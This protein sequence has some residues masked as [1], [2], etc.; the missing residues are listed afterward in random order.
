VATTRAIEQL[1][2]AYPGEVRALFS[3]A[4][5]LIR[6]LLPKVEETVDGSAPVVGYGYGPGYRGVACTLILSKSEVKLGLVRGGE[7]AD[8]RGLLEGSGKVHRYVALRRPADLR[9]AGLSRLVKAAY[10]AWREPRL[11]TR[12]R[13]RRQAKGC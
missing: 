7:L 13:W 5:G 8:L 6:R 1:L 4:R 10:A 11:D 12:R 9:K 3:G 2:Q